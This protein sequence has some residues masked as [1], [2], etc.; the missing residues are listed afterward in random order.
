MVASRHEAEATQAGRLTPAQPFSVVTWM[1]ILVFRIANQVL[2]NNKNDNNIR[3]LLSQ[4][5]IA[6]LLKRDF[7]K[8]DSD[9]AKETRR[10]AQAC[11]PSAQHQTLQLP[12]R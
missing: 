11:R 12:A 8:R 1:H 10:L 5:P 9:M 3:V 2:M 4:F 7:P 6:S